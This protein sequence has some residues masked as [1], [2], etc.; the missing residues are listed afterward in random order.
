MEVNKMRSEKLIREQAD[1][2]RLGIDVKYIF[3]SAQCPHHENLHGKVVEFDEAFEVF[4]IENVPS[5]CRC[6]CTQILVDEK[7]EPFS[8]SLV[9]RIKSQKK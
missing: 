8:P 6:A 7:G 1:A 3:M 4:S 9:K 5:G 2:A